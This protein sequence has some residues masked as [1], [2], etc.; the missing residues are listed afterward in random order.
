MPGAGKH[1]GNI[2]GK[3]RQERAAYVMKPFLYFR[4][5]YVIFPSI[6]PLN[7]A[8]RVLSWSYPSIP[9]AERLFL[10]DEL[11]KANPIQKAQKRTLFQTRKISVLDPKPDSWGLSAP[12]MPIPRRLI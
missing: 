1:P 12:H 10:R 5:K 9:V 6:L 7:L 8:P 4:T 2:H 3:F 11:S